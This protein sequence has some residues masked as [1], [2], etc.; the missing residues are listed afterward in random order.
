MDTN[1][2]KKKWKIDEDLVRYG[3]G[4]ILTKVI[5]R[6]LTTA[7]PESACFWLLNDLS[8]ILETIDSD[9]IKQA[10][11]FIGLERTTPP[12]E[13]IKDDLIADARAWVC[14]HDK[15]GA[16]C[17][18]WILN[19]M[20]EIEREWTANA[21]T[22]D[23]LSF[24]EYCEDPARWATS[25]GAPKVKMLG[26]EVRSMWAWAFDC[27]RRGVSIYERAKKSPNVAHVALKEESKKTRLVI[28]TPMASYL[29]QCYMLYRSGKCVS[30]S[31]PIS[32]HDLIKRMMVMS[33]EQ[34]VS[35]DAKGFDHQIPLW[36][37]QEVVRM[38]GRVSGCQELAD[39]ELRSM[40]GMKVEL[41]GTNI[42]Y[43]GGVL[44]GWRL[45]S[46]IGSM[47]S[48]FLCRFVASRVPMLRWAVLGDDV[49]MMGK[50]LPKDIIETAINTFGLILKDPVQIKSVGVFLQRIYGGGP[51]IMCFGRSL[52]QL[53]YANP[54]VERL[55]FATPESLA[56]GWLQ[57]ISRIPGILH[58]QWLLEQASLDMA[59]WA[60]WPGWGKQRWYELLTTDSGYGGLGTMDTHIVRDYIPAIRTTVEETKRGH[61]TWE[62]L[63]SI[64][65]PSSTRK[66]DLQAQYRFVNVSHLERMALRVTGIVRMTWDE[67]TNI[68]Q[69]L[70]NIMNEG[71]SAIPKYI[72]EINCICFFKIIIACMIL[73]FLCCLGYSHVLN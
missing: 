2:K 25:G 63:Y 1:V 14:E 16:S 17:K 33:H 9:K 12:A 67:R 58:R 59:R 53:F 51:S 35:V 10:G 4:S 11:L 6:A 34:Y 32:D 71:A 57:A 23:M 45:T 20:A 43:H 73:L 46:L 30:L 3:P 7:D 27:K 8:K 22:G 69:V 21:P 44:S 24:E 70:Y 39:E 26:E 62:K 72:R 37:I 31:S 61:E 38:V 42:K 56:N 40:Q 60:R 41:F 29:R 47:A 5:T 54:W 52:K 28:T 50:S 64:L 66:K 36:F 13:F 68:T 19:E 65:I 48:E 49:L 15:W 18:N 55:Q